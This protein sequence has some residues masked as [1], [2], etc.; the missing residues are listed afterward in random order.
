MRIRKPNLKYANVVLIED[1]G[2][3]EPSIYEEAA[4][5][6]EWK[7]VME[8]EMMALKQ[9]ETWELVP[10]SIRIQPILCK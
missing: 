1:N 5:S 8:E 10:P 4:Q 9:N 2:I 7:D 6:K 3:N